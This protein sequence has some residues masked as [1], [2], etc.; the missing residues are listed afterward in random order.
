MDWLFKTKNKKN[1][2]VKATPGKADETYV[3]IGL[4]NSFDF[5]QVLSLKLTQSE[6]YRIFDSTYGLVA[7]RVIGNEGLGIPNCRISIFI[8]KENETIQVQSPLD[9]ILSLLVEQHYPYESVTDEDGDGRRYNL[10]A[11][12]SKNRGFNGFPYN[13]LNLGYTPKTPIGS[14]PEKEELLGNDFFLTV[15]EKYY[16][17]STVTNDSGDYMIFGVPVGTYTIHMDCDLT[18]IGR[19]SVAPVIMSQ[20]LGYPSSLFSD[21]GTKIQATTD[22]DRLPNIQSQNISVNILPFWTQQTDKKQIG[23][24]RQD[25]KI[26]APIIPSFTIFGSNFTMARNRWWGDNVFF[27]L[28]YGWKN[29]CFQIGDVDCSKKSC[30]YEVSFY[31][32]I[33]I[34]WL[35]I[36]KKVTINCDKHPRGDGV[37]FGFS[38][39]L[40][41]KIPFLSFEFGDNLCRIEGGK[42]DS[43]PFDIINHG[44]TCECHTSD[45]LLE[46]PN[47]GITD[48]LMLSNHRTDS[49]NI[50]L[51]SLKKSISDD[52]AIE[53]NSI[54]RGNLGDGPIKDNP[55]LNRV[56]EVRDIEV[57]RE[58]RYATLI[59]PGQF[60]L[61]IPTNR[62][63]MITDEEGNLVDSPNASIGVYTEFRG[64]LYITT[65]GDFDSPEGKFTAGRVAMKIPQYFDYSA[66][67]TNNN[68][69][70]ISRKLTR[71]KEWIFNHGLFKAG[72]IYSVAQK[73]AIKNSDFDSNN[74]EGNHVFN[75]GGTDDNPRSKEEADNPF[76]D[77]NALTHGSGGDNDI[78]WDTQTGLLLF[79]KDTDLTL[80][81]K[82]GWLREGG[83][84]SGTSFN[85]TGYTKTEDWIP[86]T[87][88]TYVGNEKEYKD[89][90]KN[91]NKS[92]ASENG[93]TENTPS[94]LVSS[95]TI[96]ENVAPIVSSQS[97]NDSGYAS[98]PLITGTLAYYPNSMPYPYNFTDRGVV[99][100]TWITSGDI[101]RLTTGPTTPIAVGSGIGSI[102]RFHPWYSALPGDII[103]LSDGAIN[104]KLLTNDGQRYL[105]VRY[106]VIVDILFLDTMNQYTLSNRYAIYGK[107]ETKF[108]WVVMIPKIEA[109]AA[110]NASTPRTNL[111]V[112]IHFSF[113]ENTDINYWT[114]EILIKI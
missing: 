58:G 90:E 74:E 69:V 40:P 1:I 53:I 42:Y 28:H 86:P 20:V 60:I 45:A 89:Y 6:V 95:G 106:Y 101:T 73:L 57:M 97:F 102:I 26:I 27:R 33:I 83:I 21:N 3:T 7:G 41:N 109:N 62:H 55:V 15:Y 68:G 92:T 65:D 2:R 70:S 110:A 108:D 50:K 84:V 61:Q 11:N 31:L 12:Q 24:T 56:S 5:L 79:T 59:E 17:Y 78:G 32:G 87:H 63:P 99:A 112:R 46:I 48:A 82:T 51:F 94:D 4:T 52:D 29:L 71:Y 25:F 23:I 103:E 91:S 96:D 105:D 36:D 64:Y 39:Q 9:S 66:S 80:T 85:S 72:E 88:T 75:G 107:S 16:K 77:I 8:P 13:E 98:A 47:S 49:V 76:L 111:R 44:N 10:L 104:W 67:S 81:P 19:W 35:D 113:S 114:P 14:F 54:I 43:N 18:D 34:G 22:L 93:V 30:D 38:F 37:H 100:Q